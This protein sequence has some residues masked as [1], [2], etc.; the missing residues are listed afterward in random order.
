[1]P[2]I[3]P[4]GLPAIE[5]LANE[6]ITIISESRAKS[7]D[8]RPLKIVILNLMPTKIATENQLIRVLSNTPLQ[9]EIT[10]LQTETYESKNVEPEHLETF[11]KAFHEI[12][13]LCFDGL[14]VTGAPVENLAFEQ[15]D[16][17]NELC[18]ILIWSKTNV[19][20][21]LHI[22]W[23]TQAGLYFHYGIPKYEIDKKLSGIYTHGVKHQRH[24]LVRGFDEEFLAPHSRYTEIRVED[25]VKHEGL[26][27]LS[28]SA[29]AGVY[30][31]AS[32][33]F[34]QVYITGHPEYDAHTLMLEYVRDIE[35]GIN[36][37]VPTNYFPEDNPKLLARNR[38][39]GHAYLLFSN[40]LNHVY[41]EVPYELEKIKALDLK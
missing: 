31:V 33:D 27:I 16:Y 2:V 29:D 3:V 35:K 34:R 7:Q 38:W 10:F 4:N 36:P 21:T 20:S 37:D 32:I 19:F 11:Y 5:T 40:W 17:W 15:V 13:Q 1:M 24:P 30:M 28:T 23:G 9:I 22:C 14:I 41:Q 26:E 25:I 8:I 12:K 18:E 39:R 6:N